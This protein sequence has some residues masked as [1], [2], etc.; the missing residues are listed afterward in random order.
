M[1]LLAARSA[2]HL[3]AFKH[4]VPSFSTMKALA[5]RDT[6]SLGLLACA[7]DDVRLSDNGWLR[8][9]LRLLCRFS[10]CLLSPLRLKCRPLVARRPHRLREGR[11]LRRQ[12]DSDLL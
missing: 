7:S 8:A 6:A 11:V 5:F 9:L 2:L 3:R 10:A 1:A 4:Q 12:D